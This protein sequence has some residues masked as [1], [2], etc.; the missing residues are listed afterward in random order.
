MISLETRNQVLGKCYPERRLTRVRVGTAVKYS[1][2]YGRGTTTVFEK[3]M[4]RTTGT[5]VSPCPAASRLKSTISQSLRNFTC[6][7]PSTRTNPRHSALRHFRCLFPPC[8]YTQAGSSSPTWREQSP[9]M[10]SATS[11]APCPSEEQLGKL[12][13]VLRLTP[14]NIVRQ[15]GRISSPPY[16]GFSRR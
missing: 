2:G 3:M 14:C 8:R 4:S 1:A 7:P 6:L 13:G 12:L 9:F 10:R 5:T 15:V 11:P 16:C